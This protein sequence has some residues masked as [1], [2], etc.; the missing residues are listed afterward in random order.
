M[1]LRGFGTISRIAAFLIAL[2]GVPCAPG[3]GTTGS[4]AG[5]HGDQRVVRSLGGAF[6]IRYP[7]RLDAMAETVDRFLC[8]SAGAIA[9]SLGLDTYDTI[10]VMIAPGIEGYRQSHG[11]RLPDWSAAY[12]NTG[13]QILGINSRAVAGMRRPIRTVIR[14]ELSHLLF[15]QRVGGVDCPA[16]FLEGLAMRQS[17]EWGFGDEWRFTG[18]VV[19]KEIPYLED[20]EGRFPVDADDAAFAYGIS[21]IAVTELLGERPDDLVTITAFI[22]EFGDFDEAFATTFGESPEHFDGRLH[23]ILLKRYRNTGTL[24]QTAPYWLFLTLLFLLA[25]GLRRYRNRRRLEEWERRES[26]GA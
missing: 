10:T 6:I 20:L 15:A 1:D 19:R 13:L 22:R 12:S 16:W 4:S 7:E 18:R 26:N 24:I 17:G 8:E 5:D 25:F 14:H 3:A 9:T 11:G 21:Y 2:T 23:V